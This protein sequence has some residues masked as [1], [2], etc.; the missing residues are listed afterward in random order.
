M[1]NVFVF[2]FFKGICKNGNKVKSRSHHPDEAGEQKGRS[3]SGEKRFSTSFMELEWPEGKALGASY[4]WTA[5]DS[6]FKRL[7]HARSC[8]R[9]TCVT[10]QGSPLPTIQQSWSLF[11]GGT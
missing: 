4:H 10:V 7:L 8:Q 11:P 9:R 2:F 1:S 3:A 6:P 5:G